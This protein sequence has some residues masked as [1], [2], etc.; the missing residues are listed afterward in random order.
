MMG[1]LLSLLML[2][3]PAVQQSPVIADLQFAVSADSFEE[4]AYEFLEYG[5]GDKETITELVALLQEAG[6]HPAVFRRA[7]LVLGQLTALVN[8][9]TPTVKARLSEWLDIFWLTLYAS[10]PRLMS[11]EEE[12]EWLAWACAVKAR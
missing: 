5:V 10:G 8:G 1:F 2:R 3:A 9:Q 7:S 4:A 11:P 6:T 12:T